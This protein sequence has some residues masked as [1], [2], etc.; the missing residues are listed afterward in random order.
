MSIE[1]NGTCWKCHISIYSNEV[2]ERMERE[3]VT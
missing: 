2:Y 3:K 1:I